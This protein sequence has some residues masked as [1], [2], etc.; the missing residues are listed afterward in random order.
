MF[1]VNAPGSEPVGFG[2][3]H[4]IQ[5]VSSNLERSVALANVAGDSE[6][7]ITAAVI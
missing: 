6:R 1:A 3:I 5:I 4:I 2:K 7:N